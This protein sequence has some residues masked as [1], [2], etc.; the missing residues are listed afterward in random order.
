MICGI[1]SIMHK[2]FYAGG[3]IFHPDSEQILL[4]QVTSD[5]QTSSPWSLFGTSFSDPEKSE[6]AFKDIISQTLGLK[7][8]TVFPVY[9]SVKDPTYDARYILFAE[10]DKL[11]EFP[12]KANLTFGWFS[13]KAILKLQ[14]SAQEKHD[15]VVGQRV[16]AAA[17]R[18]SNG[19][20]T[21]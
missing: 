5:S 3:F 8:E 1:I 12:P 9:A 6:E 13:F 21:L 14:I 11:T 15:I 10:V 17:T 16:I 19:E 4:Q 18:K 20:Q 2:K 7:L